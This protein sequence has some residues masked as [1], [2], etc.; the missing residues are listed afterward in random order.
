MQS[1][2]SI[3][4]HYLPYISFDYFYVPPEC[5][6]T[7]MTC[8]RSACV[9]V[10]YHYLAF[11][12]FYFLFSFFSLPIIFLIPKIYSFMIFANRIY[13]EVGRFVRSMDVLE[14]HFDIKV[15][16]ISVLT[17]WWLCGWHW[18]RY[19]KVKYVSV[20]QAYPCSRKILLTKQSA[21]IMRLIKNIGLLI[22]QLS[23]FFAN[24]MK[25]FLKYFWPWHLFYVSKHCTML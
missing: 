23:I 22:Y 1:S 9:S 3:P 18:W 8:F 21:V 2:S 12:F 19:P 15:S 10:H 4:L 14:M 7:I 24:H 6:Y 11:F 5:R 20:Y 25:D 13:V 17:Y 16:F